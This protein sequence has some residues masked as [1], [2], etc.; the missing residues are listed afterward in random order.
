MQPWTN[1]ITT[2]I[3]TLCGTPPKQAEMVIILVL[4]IAVGL[5]VIIKVGHSLKF[6]MAEYSR[7]LP[8]IALWLVLCI[9]TATAV[10]LYAVP[11]LPAGMA[12]QAAPIAAAV[13]IFL[14]AVCP[15]AC[16]LFKSHYF[17]TLFALLMGL[18]AA[19]IIVFAVRAAADAIRQGGKGLA[20]TKDRTEKVNE[21]IR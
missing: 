10:Q 5:F 16:F 18:L 12:A 6:P 3:Q 14:A 17:Q 4:S 9:L 11:H 21:A 7:A 13:L 8:V 2:M 1:T 19:A 15:L 20:T